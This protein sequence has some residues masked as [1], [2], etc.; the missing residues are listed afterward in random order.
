VH[1]QNPA[2]RMYESCGFKHIE[3]RGGYQLMV[4]D[5]A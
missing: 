4:V 2:V 1:P 5:L 3:L